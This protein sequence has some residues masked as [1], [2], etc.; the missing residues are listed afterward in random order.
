MRLVH[1]YARVLRMLRDESRLAWT[2]ALANLGLA[3]A[4]FADPVLFGRI[5]DALIGSGAGAPAWPV[6]TPLLLAWIGF[7]LFT[8][9]CGALTA[10]NADRLAHRHRHVVLTD[11]FEH[12]LQLPLSYHGGTHSGR[13]LKVM[14]AGTDSIWWLWLSFFR[15]HLTAAVSLFVL[16]PLSLFLNWHLALL[17]IALC[18]VFTLLTALVVRKA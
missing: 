3:A 5:I 12:I 14:L 18:I 9:V 17:L 2:L 1:L 16:L 11:Y 10:L 8:I 7:A 4:Q 15:E 6:L 13:L